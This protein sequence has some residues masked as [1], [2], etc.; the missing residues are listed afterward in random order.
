[1]TQGAWASLGFRGG[2]LRRYMVVAVVLLAL[3]ISGLSASGLYALYAYRSL[4]KSLSRMDAFRRSAALVESVND[5]RVTVAQLRVVAQPLHSLPNPE[6]HQQLQ[7]LRV[8]FVRCITRVQNHLESYGL[9]LQG[10][11]G[12]RSLPLASQHQQKH[13]KEIGQLL[14]QLQE[15]A[16]ESDPRRLAQLEQQTDRLGQLSLE[17]PRLL[18]QD[19]LE[20]RQRMESTYRTFWTLAWLAA[21]VAAGVLGY[22][23]L[24]TWERLVRPLLRL[25]EDARRLARGEFAHRIQVSHRNEL[26]QLAAAW[27]RV[28]SQFQSIQRRLHHQV[29]QRL[30]QIASHDR[31]AA[32]GALA[33]G[34]SHEVNN[35]LASIAI[36]AESLQRHLGRFEGQRV[37]QHLRP[38]VKRYV[39]LLGQEAKRCQEIVEKLLGR[40]A[41]DSPPGGPIPL[42]PAVREVV[43]AVLQIPKYQRRRVHLR[44][45]PA[46]QAFV[47]Q[48]PWKQVV[49]NLVVNALQATQPGQQVQVRLL[50]Q[51]QRV[52]LEVV[53]QG[54]GIRP[55][56]LPRVFEPFFTKRRDQRGT[57]LGLYLVH[58]LVDSW[59]GQ[60]LAHSPGPGQGARFRVILPTPPLQAKAA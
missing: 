32:A 10:G 54:C 1:M 46:A 17:L 5:L 45:D 35:P 22:L 24:G 9:A 12:Q 4:V 48:T 16:W 55:E 13:L 51:P 28:A 34:V 49:L 33:A 50:R 53:D 30:R 60:V 42:A 36:S 14:N 3:A 37:P 57:G 41:D 52:I 40:S 2:T 59:G 47:P 58:K 19:V 56:D 38:R 27:N 15:M 8:R 23:V 29:Q 31:L 44:L 18:R 20:F 21:L 11:Q 43:E 39:E 7:Q 25:L 6:A 26:S